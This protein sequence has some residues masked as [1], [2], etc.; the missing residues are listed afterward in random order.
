MCGNY[1]WF[2]CGCSALHPL[3]IGTV[4]LIIDIIVCEEVYIW[5]FEL[6]WLLLYHKRGGGWGYIGLLTLGFIG[7]HVS[8]ALI[9]KCMLCTQCTARVRTFKVVIYSKNNFILFLFIWNKQI[10]WQPLININKI[11][12]LILQFRDRRFV[13]YFFY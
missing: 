4:C 2:I 3:N 11:I 10:K 7:L 8:R 12:I 1:C 9:E 5:N 13:R 6:N